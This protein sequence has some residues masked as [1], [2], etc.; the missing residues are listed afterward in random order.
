MSKIADWIIHK[1][2][3][4][5]KAEAMK[6]NG[7]MARNKIE[8]TTMQKSIE[9]LSAQVEAPGM[10]ITVEERRALREKIER[11]LFNELKLRGGIELSWHHNKAT[12]HYYCRG[13]IRV[14][15]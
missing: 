5:T 14:M 11:L 1:L 7:A 2:G 15:K 6:L 4:L 13:T 10:G 12:G 3:G 9:T 8:L